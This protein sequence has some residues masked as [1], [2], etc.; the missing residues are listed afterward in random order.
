[1]GLKLNQLDEIAHKEERLKSDHFGIETYNYD[2]N[3][4]INDL[5]KSDH[6]GIE[7]FLKKY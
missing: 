1:M 5:L 4:L 3:N 7:T 2:V 6:F